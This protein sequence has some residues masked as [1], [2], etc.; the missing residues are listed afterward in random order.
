ME[1]LIE[2]LNAAQSIINK[3]YK[4]AWLVKEYENGEKGM[5]DFE[6]AEEFYFRKIVEVIKK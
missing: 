3:F 2:K 5:K 1:E 6:S 4:I